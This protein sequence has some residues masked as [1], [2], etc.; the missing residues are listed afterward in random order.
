MIDFEN[1]VA[2]VKRVAS[3]GSSDGAP[4]CALELPPE[5]VRM[6]SRGVAENFSAELARLVGT[7]QGLPGVVTVSCEPIKRW[8]GGD[9]CGNYRLVGWRLMVS[10][11][12]RP[13]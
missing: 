5:S 13:Q 8:N 10:I 11:H 2:H 6:T 7:L 4:F 9:M 12:R 1:V 3:C